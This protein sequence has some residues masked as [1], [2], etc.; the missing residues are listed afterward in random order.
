M[1]TADEVDGV[2]SALEKNDLSV[3]ARHSNMLKEEPRLFFMH[4]WGLGSADAVGGG[5]KTALANVSTK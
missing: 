2:I 3:T 5:I 1:L 4:F